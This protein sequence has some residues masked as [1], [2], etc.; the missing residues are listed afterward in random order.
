MMIIITQQ[1]QNLLTPIQTTTTTTTTSL[2][3]Q[4]D[5]TKLE[6]GSYLKSEEEKKRQLA[7][8]EARKKME[9]I[10]AIKKKKEGEFLDPRTSKF[11]LADL[12]GKFPKGVDPTKKELYLSA[13]DFKT[14]FGMTLAEYVKLPPVQ[15]KKLKK[16]LNLF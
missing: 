8:E 16:N 10:E 13:E 4:Q 12:Q 6:F 5:E 11:K 3:T 9:A 14:H 2:S 7:E 1:Q 15:K